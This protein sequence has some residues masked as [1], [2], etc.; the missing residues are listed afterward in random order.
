MID[1]AAAMLYRAFHSYDDNNNAM[2]L[3][4]RNFNAAT[5]PLFLSP[6]TFYNAAARA[7]HLLFLMPTGELPRPAHVIFSL[8]YIEIDIYF[9][10]HMLAGLCRLAMIAADGLILLREPA[11]SRD[12]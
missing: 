1:Y 8:V 10:P 7:A 4:L 3:S 12:A 2:R 9:S 11:S 5:M 6:A